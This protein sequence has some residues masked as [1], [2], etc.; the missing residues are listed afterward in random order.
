M[1]TALFVWVTCGSVSCLLDSV[2]RSRPRPSLPSEREMR[3]ISMLQIGGP[4]SL[5]VLLTRLLR[6]AM[7]ARHSACR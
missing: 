3:R 1:V 7:Q 6:G 4:I 5:L 2:M